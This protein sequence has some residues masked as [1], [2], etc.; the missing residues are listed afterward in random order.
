MFGLS[1]QYRMDDDDDDDDD[2]CGAVGSMGTGKRNTN[3]LQ[4]GFVHH[5]S[6]M[7]SP[8]IEPGPPRWELNIC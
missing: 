3:V 2:E 4:R 7:S 5:K 6:H 8:W 1:Y